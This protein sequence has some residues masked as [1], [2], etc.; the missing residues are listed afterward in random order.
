MCCFGDIVI[1]VHLVLAVGAVVHALRELE[2]VG[3]NLMVVVVK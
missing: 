1:M 3:W 2:D